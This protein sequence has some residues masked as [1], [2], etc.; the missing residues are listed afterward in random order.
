MKKVQKLEVTTS[1]P[2]KYDEFIYGKYKPRFR[3]IAPWV[4]L[5]GLF[6]YYFAYLAAHGAE[7][8]RIARIV[9][10]FF[11]VPGVVLFWSIIG[12]VTLA[13]GI[14]AWLG[15]RQVKNEQA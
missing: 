14:E 15:S 11:G 5:L 2:S 4:A 7:P 9:Y 12:T 1:L 8:T 6:S 3:D 13:G 10:Q